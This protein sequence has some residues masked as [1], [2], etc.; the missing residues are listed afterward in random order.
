MLPA[1]VLQTHSQ[2]SAALL[3][4]ILAEYPIA[5]DLYNYNSMDAY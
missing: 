2:P 3:Y 4:V 5:L 1:A